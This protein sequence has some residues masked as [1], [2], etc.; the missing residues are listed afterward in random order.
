V[1]DF[2]PV[3]SE[4]RFGPCYRL[5]DTDRELLQETLEWFR[6][7]AQPGVSV[8]GLYRSHTLPECELCQ[9]DEELMRSHFGAAEDLVL[10]VKP[11]L[12][13]SSEADFVMRRCGRAAQPPV[14]EPPPFMTW[15][16][17]RPRASM[18]EPEP[19][20]PVIHSRRGVW[21]WS[22]YVA[23]TLLGL[24]GG[25]LGYLWWHP[26]AGVERIAV[27]SLAPPAPPPAARPIVEGTP[28]PPEPDTA[29]IHG[30]LDR[31]SSA[32]KRGDV[33]AA[34]QCYAPVVGTYFARHDVT[35]EAVRQS[36]RQVR[37]RY[38]R[39]DVYRISGLAIMPVSDS[40]AVA[41]FRKH[42]HWRTSGRGRS[43]GEEE[44]RMTLV[45]DGGVWRISSEQLEAR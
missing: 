23:A 29:A 36:I 30:L 31:W 9:E 43:A 22:V 8:L 34:A 44:E 4:H 20:G 6:G 13:G 21:R 1:E 42:W 11:N 16:P 28:A 7:G 12:M 37:A 5:S 41:T 40:R 3:P 17:P 25:A 27:S 14:P 18:L 35:R 15:P 2:E 32:L 45:R 24:V 38:G 19:E 33:E 26:D 10:L 39:P